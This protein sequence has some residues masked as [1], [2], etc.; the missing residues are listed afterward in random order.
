MW[1]SGGELL[2]TMF[3]REQECLESSVQNIIDSERDEQILH[4]NVGESRAHGNRCRWNGR[5]D[6]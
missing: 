5:C 1:E 2:I 6:R 4:I 3:L